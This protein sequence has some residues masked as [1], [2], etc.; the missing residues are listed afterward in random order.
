MNTCCRACLNQIINEGISLNSSIEK[1]SVRDLIQYCSG[2][3]LIINDEF[4]QMICN[5]CL[6]KILSACE[7]KEKCI[8]SNNILHEQIINDN[9]ENLI[10]PPIMLESDIKEDEPLESYKVF[11]ERRISFDEEESESAKSKTQSNLFKCYLCFEKFKYRKEKYEHLEII[12]KNNE[13]KCKLCRHKSQTIRGL[14]NHIML[15]ENPHLLSY[16]CHVCSKHYQK[17]SELRRHIKL[18][19]DDKS[20]RVINFYCDNCDFKTFSKM[21]MKRHLNTI[22]LKIKAFAC[23]FC[24]EKKYTSKI[25]LEQHKITKH[26]KESDFKC[27]CCHRKFPTMSFLRSHMKTC[28]GNTSAIRERGD[29]NYYREPLENDTYRCKLCGLVFIG[30]GKIAQHYA[31]RHKHSNVCDI[32]NT[33]FNSYSNLKKHIQ[34]LHN[35]IHKYTCS[36]CSKTFGQKNQLQSHINTHTRKKPFNCKFDFCK[37]RSGDLSAVSKHQKKCQ[38]NPANVIL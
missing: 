1:R 35:K 20:K 32:C 17:A 5:E 34:I 14:D 13:L 7:I 10:L 21:N 26:G 16:M 24:P 15:H 33:S 18:A 31:Q 2:I 29:P 8:N 36:F 12:H 38:N 22:H 19:H 11:Q 30:K 28:S 37:F 6:E 4:P 9:E 3:E 27:N 23:E 25:T